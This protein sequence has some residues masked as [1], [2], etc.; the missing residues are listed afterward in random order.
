MRHRGLSPPRRDCG[1]FGRITLDF[2][3]EEGKLPNGQ[4]ACRQ[5]KGVEIASPSRDACYLPTANFD[6]DVNRP[7]TARRRQTAEARLTPGELA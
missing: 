5:A 1:G 3:S 7:P 4:G 6:F 2:G